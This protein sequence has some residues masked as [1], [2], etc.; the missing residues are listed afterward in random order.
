MTQQKRTP[1]RSTRT[2]V[3]S[4]ALLSGLR[5]YCCHEQGCRSPTL[6]RRPLAVAVAQTGS[7]S[8]DLTP[9]L[10]TS[11]CCWFDP[12]KIFKEKNEKVC[13][14][15]YK[16]GLLPLTKPPPAPATQI[17][18]TWQLAGRSSGWPGSWA[19]RA[20]GSGSSRRRQRCRRPCTGDRRGCRGPAERRVT[21]SDAKGQLTPGQELNAADATVHDHPGHSC[22][23]T[24]TTAGRQQPP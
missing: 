9:S 21:S 15:L 16:C 3:R 2:Q 13:V 4:L 1:L 24:P 12:E 7:C 5:I 10:G 6:L 22:M 8:Y 18:S 23:V 14:I 11:T 19:A 17:P 20:Q